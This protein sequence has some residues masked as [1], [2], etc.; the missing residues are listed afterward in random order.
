MTV[1]DTFASLEAMEEVLAMGAEE[2]FVQAIGQ[3]YDL[4]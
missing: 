1:L 4:I 3:I 2:G